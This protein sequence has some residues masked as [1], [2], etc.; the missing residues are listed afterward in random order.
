MTSLCAQGNSHSETEMA[1]PKLLPQPQFSRTSL[2]DVAWHIFT[3][4][5]NL[6]K[7]SPIQNKQ[8]IMYLLGFPDIPTPSQTYPQSGAGHHRQSGSDA[9]QR[10]SR[11]SSYFSIRLGSSKMRATCRGASRSAHSGQLSCTRLSVISIR[12]YCLRQHRQDR[13]LHPWSSGSCSA[14]WRT[15]H[16]G[17][18]RSSWPPK[19]A[20]LADNGSAGSAVDGSDETFVGVGGWRSCC[21]WSCCCWCSC[22]ARGVPTLAL[23]PLDPRLPWKRLWK[24]IL[25]CFLPGPRHFGLGMPLTEEWGDSESF[26]DPISQKQPCY[27]LPLESLERSESSGE[28]PW[29]L[30][31]NDFNEPQEH[32]HSRYTK[33]CL[34]RSQQIPVSFPVGRIPFM[35]SFLPLYY[36]RESCLNNKRKDN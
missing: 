9:R 30:P 28:A 27:V 22:C 32:G 20:W 16:R 25:P 12:K 29:F 24:E 33:E 6:N 35:S 8:G 1:L 11:N 15:R 34:S 10:R 5:M 2:Y 17:H 21:C 26:S 18:S 7:T 3:G 14:G 36:N 4:I 31:R 13:W 19:E 23:F